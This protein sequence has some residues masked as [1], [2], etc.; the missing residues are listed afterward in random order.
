MGSTM[1]KGLSVSY[2]VNTQEAFI[3]KNLHNK[4][5]LMDATAKYCEVQVKTKH[6]PSTNTD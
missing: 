6:S 3:S 2:C 1:N 4:K 5:A